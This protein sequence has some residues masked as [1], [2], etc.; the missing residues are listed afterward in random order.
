M[1]EEVRVLDRAQVRRCA[2]RLDPV[3]VTE[4]ILRR[5]ARGQ[6]MLPAEGY[7][8]WN[9]SEGAYSRS[10]AMLGALTG[11]DPVYGIKLINAAV[12]NPSKGIERA[13]GMSILFDPETARPCF[14]AEAGYLSALRTSA[15]TV[16]SLRHLGPETFDAV[17]VIGCGALARAHLELIARYFPGVSRAHVF[18]VDPSRA[19][20]FREWAT[21]HVPSV[22]VDTEL[23]ARSC[24][25]ASQVVITLTVSNEPYADHD[26][27]RPGTF[28]AHVSLDDL[29]EDV[30]AEA[31]RLY[32]DDPE[33]IAENP[34]RILGRLLQEGAIVPADG[35]ITG[36]LGEV[37]TGKVSAARPTGG[38]VVS[39]PFGMSILDV[40]MVDA[41]RRTAEAE[42]I[43]TR[44][45]LLGVAGETR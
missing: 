29:R 7:M 42:D 24:A 41:V 30:F 19:E 22:A 15:Y 32:V 4:D 10:I 25:A 18:D 40:G 26:W 34:R 33:L 31:E 36:S 9:N 35:G 6:V 2:A 21:T 12:S 27:F 5:H 44:I 45:D 39:N 20:L 43:G 14:L 1:R 8:A 37:L 3:A 13:G 38:V 17:S 28:I 16:A 23:S 11:P